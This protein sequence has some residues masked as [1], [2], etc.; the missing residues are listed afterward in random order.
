MRHRKGALELRRRY[1]AEHK[2]IGRWATAVAV[3]IPVFVA[4][5]GG[6]AFVPGF[7]DGEQAAMQAATADSTRSPM[8]LVRRDAESALERQ[9]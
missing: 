3:A 2:A 5:L 4:L 8:S 1:L 9:R 7:G 6:L